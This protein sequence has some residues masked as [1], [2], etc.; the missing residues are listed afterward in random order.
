VCTTWND[1]CN[2]II[3]C[4]FPKIIKL[5]TKF[6]KPN[7]SQKSALICSLYCPGHG[8]LN[9]GLNCLAGFGAETFLAVNQTLKAST[10]KPA[11]KCWSI[12]WRKLQK[13]DLSWGVAQS[14]E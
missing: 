7:L 11:L 2:D 13:S 6:I 9:S 14:H 3:A 8:N 12:L 10:K 5:K 4:L 1:I